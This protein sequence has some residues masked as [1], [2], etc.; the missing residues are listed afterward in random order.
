MN[1]PTD[2]P[3][4]DELLLREAVTRSL[5]G[6][7]PDVEAEWAAFLGKKLSIHSKSQS[8]G[9][10]TPFPHRPAPGGVR[11]W[12]AIAAACAVA[13]VLMTCV[14]L[15]N[16]AEPRAT[17]AWARITAPE[18]QRCLTTLPDGTRIWLSGGS[19]LSYPAAFS[20]SDRRV[21][22]EGEAFFDVTKDPEH[23]FVVRTQYLTARVLGTQFSIQGTSEATS[24]VTLYT[25]RV[26]VTPARSNAT[27]VTLKPGQAATLAVGGS[28]RVA[29]SAPVPHLAAEEGALEFSSAP[30]NEVLAELAAWYN[31]AIVTPAGDIPTTTVH[32]ALDLGTSPADAVALLNLL[33]IAHVTLDGGRLTVE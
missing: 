31:L 3:I 7:A 26:L 13:C 1:N 17:Q 25:G 2:N 12:K 10:R 29:E 23:P 27:T 9:D 14:A 21:R 16:V 15:M 22:L 11:L 19:T 24:R 20:A 30:F 8:A 28:P 33:D 32:F 5:S 4:S 18:G 6:S